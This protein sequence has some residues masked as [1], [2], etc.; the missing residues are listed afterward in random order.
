MVWHPPSL[1]AKNYILGTK[2]DTDLLQG[3]T[4][5]GEK[6]GQLKGSFLFFSAMF[7]SSMFTK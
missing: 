7:T 3:R 2:E 6:A 5:Q 1:E 4:R